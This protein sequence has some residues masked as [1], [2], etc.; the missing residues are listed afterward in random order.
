MLFVNIFFLW[1]TKIENKD[2]AEI[3]KNESEG[4]ERE[5]SFKR[6]EERL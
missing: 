3:Q 2:Q 1:E 5:L 6:K 4:K